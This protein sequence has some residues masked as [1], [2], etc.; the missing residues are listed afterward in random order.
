VNLWLNLALG[1]IAIAILVV[2]GLDGYDGGRK[3]VAAS[4][5]ALYAVV[6][7]RYRRRL[8]EHVPAG[9]SD[10]LV[11]YATETGAARQLA[12]NT[13]RKLVKQGHRVAVTEL[14]RLADSP[15][16]ARA[17]LVIASTTG[18]GDA[19]R[20]AHGWLDGAAP[21]APY[22][23]LDYAVLA[24]GDRSYPAFCGFGLQVSAELSSAG[25]R[26][27]CEPVLVSC[28]D[29]ASIRYWYQQLGLE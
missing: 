19:P 26:P 15:V 4:A 22:R 23:G 5:L 6:L 18:N 7:L 12:K 1:G 25:A 17:L 10:Y 14:N 9:P 24:L 16:P 13:A 21:L 27:L 2:I 29:P 11:A 3:L 20:T 8:A 28:V